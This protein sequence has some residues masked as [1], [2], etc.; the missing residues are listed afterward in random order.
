MLKLIELIIIAAAVDG[1]IAESEQDTILRILTQNQKTPPLSTA[2][3]ANIQSQ[4]IARFKNGET[5]ESVIRQAASSLDATGKLLAYAM[6]VEV[7]M[8]DNVLAVGETDFLR[9]QRKILELDPENVDKIHFSATLRY[10]FGT[11]E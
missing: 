8:S 6:A 1:K 5:R 2:Q 9:E 4:L 7:V 11:L 3:L 10:G